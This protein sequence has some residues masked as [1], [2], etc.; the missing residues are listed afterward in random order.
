MAQSHGVTYTVVYSHLQLP[1][2]FQAFS[3]Q[4]HR[5]LGQC[6]ATCYDSIITYCYVNLSHRFEMLLPSSSAKQASSRRPI[7]IHLAGTGDHVE[8]LNGAL[9]LFISQSLSLSLSFSLSRH[10]GVVVI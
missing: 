6:T 10:F 8:K 7:I 1:L 2:C 3:L 9:P 5:Q 4:S